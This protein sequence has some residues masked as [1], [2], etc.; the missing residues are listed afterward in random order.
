MG[1]KAVEMRILQANAYAACSNVVKRLNLRCFIHA[2]RWI[3]ITEKV[4]MLNLSLEQIGKASCR[5]RV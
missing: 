4:A 1:S 2:S 5:E 3:L